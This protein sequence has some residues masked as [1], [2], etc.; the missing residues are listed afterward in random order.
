LVK[1][2]IMIVD[3][4]KN[5]DV[6]KGVSP[7]IYAGLQFLA[8]AMPDIEVGTYFINK[9]VKAIVSE[10]NTVE[11]FERGYEAHKD[12]ID[13]Q[14]PIIGLE[15]IKWSPIE[16]MSVN[17]PYEKENDR[18]FYKD[19]SPQG[20]Q[21]DIGDGTF[22]IM[23]PEDG[24]SP[25]HYVTKPELIKKITIKVSIKIPPIKA[26]IPMKAHSER[27]ANKNIR[28]LAGKPTFYWIMKALSE[29]KYI[30]EIV[31]NTDSK[32][33]GKLVKDYFDVTILERPDYLLGDTV[34]IQPLIEYDFSKTDG[35]YFLQTHSVN[36]LVTTETIDKAIEAFFSQKEHDAL[37]SVTAVQSRFYWQNGKGINHDPNHLIRTQDMEPIFEEN[38]CFYI[39]SRANN[40]KTRNRL[41]SN[42]MMYQIN[43]L[44]A[45]DIDNM[46]DFYWAEFL[47]QQRLAGKN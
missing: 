10:Y 3:K 5:I 23:F 34:S 29:S 43:E 41:G 7:D 15:R 21:V 24:H 31:V 39:F 37:F 8:K 26:L 32:E 2:N 46:D 40:K 30:D 11:N 25:Q 45:V 38:S 36:P 22:A 9:R 28:P 19:P 6:Y 47:L 13:I 17:I 1:Q 12:V 33:I 14:Y 16:G 27:V 4:L 35:E 44:E 42:P 20:T 18:T